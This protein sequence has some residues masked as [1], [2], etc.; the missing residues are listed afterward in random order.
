MEP[1]KPKQLLTK[2][3]NFK[4]GGLDDGFI[5]LGLA[6]L[7]GQI[8]GSYTRE[9][10]DISQWDVSQVT[11]M[12]AMFAQDI[13]IPQRDEE[14]QIQH[15]GERRVFN[16]NVGELDHV[17]IEDFNRKLQETMRI[18]PRYFSDGHPIGISSRRIQ[19]TDESMDLLSYDLVT[20]PS[21]PSAFLGGGEQMMYSATTTMVLSSP[22][23]KKTFIG[24]VKQFFLDIYKRWK[25]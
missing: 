14:P 22:R 10:V 21:S 6:G 16:I 3:P 17:D 7:Y 15:D 1:I 11:D 5:K 4:K 8:T 18:P 2:K 23:K 13:F 24:R 25:I 20:N 9:T 19:N 12:S